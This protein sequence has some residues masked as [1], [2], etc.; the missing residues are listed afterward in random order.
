[1]LCAGGKGVYAGAQGI[2][3]AGRFR[4]KGC[5]CREQGCRCRAHGTALTFTAQK[6]SCQGTRNRG[7]PLPSHVWGEGGGNMLNV[8]LGVRVSSQGASAGIIK[9]QRLGEEW[10]R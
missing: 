8:A 6:C 3:H 5:K 10:A 4:E 1:M 7:K 2:G 9:Y